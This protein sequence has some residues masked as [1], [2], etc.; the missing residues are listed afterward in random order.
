MVE[1]FQKHGAIHALWAISVL[2]LIVAWLLLQAPNG[3]LIGQY[4]GFA[5]SVASLVLALVAIGY[6]FVSNQG[7]SQS[8][9]ALEVS[10]RDVRSAAQNIAEVSR[11]LSEKAEILTGEV[12]RVPDAM[13]AL[14][15]KIDANALK[16]AELPAKLVQN[17]NNAGIPYNKIRTG[18]AVALY[19]LAKAEL[20]KKGFL[21][22]DIFKDKDLKVWA[23]L[24]TG[25]LIAIDGFNIFGISLDLSSDDKTKVLSLGSLKPEEM[26]ENITQRKDNT[27]DSIRNTIDLYFSS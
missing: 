16:S 2:L 27:L 7:F 1:H 23:A 22:T 14:T 24:T 3:Q 17:D 9:G 5:A 4:I 10:S 6:A 20:S 26:L 11:L 12:A 18:G 25:Y 13:L 8:V 21:L 19:L 15:E